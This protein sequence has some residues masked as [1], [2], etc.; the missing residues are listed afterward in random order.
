MK[1][2]FII[3]SLLIVVPVAT[4]IVNYKFLS[5]SLKFIAYLLWGGLFFNVTDIA[6]SLFGRSSIPMF[7]I[8]TIIE[9]IL[10]S[11]YFYQLT[12]RDFFKKII[13]IIVAIFL[14]IVILNKMFLEPI[15]KIDNYTLTVESILL[16]ILSSIYLTEYLSDNLIV[17]FQD[18]RFLITIGLMIYFGG[19]LFVFALSNEFDIWIIHNILILLLWTIFTLVF[20][21]QRY[22]VKSGG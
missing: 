4:S 1:I 21:W 19:N 2:L 9:F 18:Y 15:D 5:K 10:L 7:H 12:Q 17:S 14:G 8:Y 3:I 16:L 22:Q 6:L 11:V 13:Q 20:I